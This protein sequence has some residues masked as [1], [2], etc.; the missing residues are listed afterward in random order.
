MRHGAPESVYGVK[1][2]DM[3]TIL[4]KN[5]ANHGLARELWATGNPDARYLAALMADEKTV[6]RTDLDRWVR[7]ADWPMLR[8]AGVA[9]LAA[10]SPHGD[11]MA[12]KWIAAKNPDIASSGWA[13]L[14]GLVSIRDD[15]DL[16]LKFLKAQLK[17]VEKSIH[18]EPN[19]VRK[20]MNLFVIC[21]GCYV[22]SLHDLA[23][24]IATKIGPVK[25]DVGDTACK[26]PLATDYITKV[27]GM[28]RIGRKRKVVRC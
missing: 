18:G 13:V 22:E 19:E 2:G 5:R 6:T 3:K 28:G 20:A 21:V 1:V 17:R 24:K 10:E 23:I 7:Q 16:D 4:K 27:A 15:A 14:S 9:A 8:G 11:A 12:R 25:V 26:V